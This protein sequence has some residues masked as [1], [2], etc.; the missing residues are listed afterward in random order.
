VCDDVVVAART[1]LSKD[2]SSPGTYT[3]SFPADTAR[4][5]AKQLA[6]FR[7]LG[8]LTERVKKLERGGK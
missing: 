5:W 3:A 1:F 8:A 4:N 2:I 6:R 7:R